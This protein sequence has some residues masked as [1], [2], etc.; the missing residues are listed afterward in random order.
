[1]MH[2]IEGLTRHCGNLEQQDNVVILHVPKYMD[3]M[4]SVC[5]NYAMNVYMHSVLLWADTVIIKHLSEEF[6]RNIGI[7]VQT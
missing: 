6:L 5:L 7:L 2:S 3:N 1:M 4:K